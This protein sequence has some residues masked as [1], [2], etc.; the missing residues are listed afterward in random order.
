MDNYRI[1]EDT[2]GPVK[3][4]VNALWGPQTQRSL[5]NFKGW[6]TNAFGTD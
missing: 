2:L 5:T 6:L 3:I 1:E 4:P